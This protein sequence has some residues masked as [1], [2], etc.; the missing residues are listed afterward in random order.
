MGN[1]CNFLSRSPRKMAGLEQ[2]RR[3]AQMA[4]RWQGTLLPLHRQQNYGCSSENRVQLRRRRPNGAF[5][6]QSS[7][8]VCNV[9]AVLLRRQWRRTEIPGQLATE[10]R[11][12]PSVSDPELELKVELIALLFRRHRRCDIRKRKR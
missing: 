9:R 1:I 8:N 12:D 3:S 7:R 4:R 6:G 10:D 2:R 11:V 5:P